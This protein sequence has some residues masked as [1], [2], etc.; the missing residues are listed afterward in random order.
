REAGAGIARGA[1]VQLLSLD[2]RVIMAT[3]VDFWTA[4][5]SIVLPPGTYWLRARW[6]S[7]SFVQREVTIGA[8]AVT[9]FDV[10]PRGACAPSALHGEPSDDEMATLVTLAFEV[11]QG[12]DYARKLSVPLISR[13]VPRRWLARVKRVGLVPVTSS[14]LDDL[15]DK[16]LDDR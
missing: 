9:S 4:K 1:T 3:T 14:Q 2:G 6:S 8:D 5:Y 7:S 13:D 12:S 15:A 16:R 11:M 10:S